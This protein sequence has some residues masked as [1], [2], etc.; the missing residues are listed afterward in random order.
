V[1]TASLT[2]TCCGA[3]R[4]GPGA[5]LRRRDQDYRARQQLA[6]LD[7]HSVHRVAGSDEGVDGGQVTYID[8]L[9]CSVLGYPEAG[10]PGISMWSLTF[11]TRRAD[12][13][14]EFVTGHALSNL[15]AVPLLPRW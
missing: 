3:E 1:R 6:G 10:P 9:T 4:R 12:A 7:D 13:A 5:E 2:W 8:F 11:C 15:R 14:Q